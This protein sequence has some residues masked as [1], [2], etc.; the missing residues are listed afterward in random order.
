MN[1][2]PLGIHHGRGTRTTEN[3]NPAPCTGKLDTDE[4]TL[5][6]L[7]RAELQKLAKVRLALLVMDTS[8]VDSKQENKVKANMKSES[9]ITE[10]VKLCKVVTVQ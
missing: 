6:K 9:I 7:S 2:A 8:D 5:R 10:L 1:E 3:P 4:A